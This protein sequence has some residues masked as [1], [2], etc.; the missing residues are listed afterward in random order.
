[1]LVVLR[2]FDRLPE[3]SFGTYAALTVTLLLDAL[4]ALGLGLL[5]SAAVS[6]PAQATIALPMLCF[7]Q[8]LFSGAILAVPIMATIGKAV[9][10]PMTD[11]WAFEGLGHELG[12]NRLLGEGGSPLGPPLLAQYGETFSRGTWIAWTILAG[13]ALVFL[14]GAVAV[15][16]RKCRPGGEFA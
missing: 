11:R 14:L 12:L 7:P 15:C 9:S 2:L 16:A 8:V 6:G 13:M 10:Y 5:A 4:A 1:M 3:A